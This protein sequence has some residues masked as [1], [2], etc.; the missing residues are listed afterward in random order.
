MIEFTLAEKAEILN[1]RAPVA[2][3][4]GPVLSPCIRICR[5]DSTQV[6]TGCYRTIDEIQ[7]WGGSSPERKRA[8]WKLLM[9]RVLASA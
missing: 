4:D 2:D 1:E 3:S 9:A 5:I 8:I 6:C 7:E